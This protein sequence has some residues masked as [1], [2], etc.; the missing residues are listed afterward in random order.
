MRQ[1]CCSSNTQVCDLA[2]R[3]LSYSEVLRRFT[4][5]KAW[6][7]TDA[8]CPVSQ[9]LKPCTLFQLPGHPDLC[10]SCWCNLHPFS[11]PEASG[12]L[13]ACGTLVPSHPHCLQCERNPPQ[14]SFWGGYFTLPRV[15]S[16]PIW[17]GC[18][19]GFGLICAPSSRCLLVEDILINLP[20]PALA[21]ESRLFSFPFRENVHISL[22]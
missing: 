6:N 2:S 12:G 4:S 11:Q 19:M 15:S 3:N 20:R 5:L 22:G 16:V 8:L 9:P 10:G 1:I 17:T 14:Q 21:R 13:Q 7:Y 18:L